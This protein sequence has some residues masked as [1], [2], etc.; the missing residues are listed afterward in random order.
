MLKFSI[1]LLSRSWNAKVWNRFSAKNVAEGGM[2]FQ[3][4]TYF[5]LVFF[6]KWR[7]VQLSMKINF[8]TKF[9][10]YWPWF[11]RNNSISGATSRK[12]LRKES[13]VEKVN[14]LETCCFTRGHVGLLLFFWQFMYFQFLI[15]QILVI[16]K[17]FLHESY[18]WFIV[19][20]HFFTRNSSEYAKKSERRSWSLFWMT[21]HSF[22]KC[23]KRT[24]VAVKTHFTQSSFQFNSF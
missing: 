16:F 5:K 11:S 17:I 23:V 15:W 12:A 8:I 22:H 9:F 21:H 14:S 3:T 6:V 7:N 19:T 10:T 24:P 13:L 1:D 20:L 4:Y 18:F 2:S